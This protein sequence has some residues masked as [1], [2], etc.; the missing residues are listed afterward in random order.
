MTTDNEV[1]DELFNPSRKK[2]IIKQEGFWY[3]EYEKQYPMPVP[4][5]GEWEGKKEFLAKLKETEKNTNKAYYKGWSTC[6][7]CKCHNGSFSHQYKSWKWP[8]GFIHYVRDHN[9][10]PSDE[11][12]KFIMG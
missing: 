4:F 9:V 11:F 6:R 5:V 3:S 12:I 8:E 2:E 1:L 7:L 10:K